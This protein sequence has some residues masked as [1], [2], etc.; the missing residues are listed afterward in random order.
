MTK[1]R[2][3]SVACFPEW[4]RYLID[5]PIEP[6]PEGRFWPVWDMGL[7]AVACIKFLSRWLLE[8]R[9]WIRRV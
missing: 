4:E 3:G 6:V 9:Y 1:K 8:N 5:R 7:V 2:Y